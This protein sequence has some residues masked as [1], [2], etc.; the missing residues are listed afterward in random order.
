[1]LMRYPAGFKQNLNHYFDADEEF[2][3]IDGSFTFCDVDFIAEDYA[4]LPTGYPRKAMTS[5][6]G[7]M[8]LTF[9][10]KK[11]IVSVR[12]TLPSETLIRLK[13]LWR[14]YNPVWIGFS[15]G[16]GVPNK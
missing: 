10:E 5:E 6:D 13:S 3:V 7:A 9:F 4:Y 15:E 16:I 2:Y 12:Q 11:N 14:A 1:M 8:T